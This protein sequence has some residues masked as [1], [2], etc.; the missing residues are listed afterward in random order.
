MNAPKRQ[1]IRISFG[2][3]GL[4]LGAPMM[5]VIGV[6]LDIGNMSRGGQTTGSWK[7]LWSRYTVR[8]TNRVDGR[9]VH[10][11]VDVSGVGVR[12]IVAPQGCGIEPVLDDT[13]NR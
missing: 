1:E 9:L 7:T 10:Q 6:V 13:L 8:H 4:A 5:V 11:R 12:D 2:V 3:T